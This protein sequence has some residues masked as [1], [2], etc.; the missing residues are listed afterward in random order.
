MDKYEVAVLAEDYARKRMYFELLGQRN[1]AGLNP[2]ERIES[3]V[4]YEVARAEMIQA[5]LK[6]E[7]AQVRT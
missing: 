4:A 2:D 6:L 3:A 5:K 7:A 1:I